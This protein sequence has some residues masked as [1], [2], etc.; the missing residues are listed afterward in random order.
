MMVA[1]EYK[2]MCIINSKQSMNHQTST[3][4]KFNIIK[5]PQSFTYCSM[6]PARESY[7]MVRNIVDFQ[8]FVSCF[9]Y[10]KS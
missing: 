3:F 10:L 4:S 5:P 7:Y 6:L 2:V 8:N 9:L 1:K